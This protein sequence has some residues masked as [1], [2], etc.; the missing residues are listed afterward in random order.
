MRILIVSDLHANAEALEILP[1]DYDELWILGDLVNYGPSPVEV[2][3]FARAKASLIVRGNH[4]HSVGFA[5]D[6]RCS[7]RFRAMAEATGRYTSSVVTEAQKRFLRELPTQAERQV[8]GARFLACHAVP[9]NP[10]YEYCARDS[11]RWHEE[12]LLMT[13]DILLTGH[14]HVPFDRTIGGK[15]IIN[16]GSLGQPKHGQPEACYAIWDSGRVTQ[17]A[18]LYAVEK[19]IRKIEALPVP[20][21]IRRDLCAVLGSGGL[22]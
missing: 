16:P 17:H 4:D 1:R 3:E 2:I 14:T 13:A 18:S 15:R 12:V 20:E 7:A 5:E 10:L 11:A 9:S 22:P 8:D 19:T 6:P 21:E